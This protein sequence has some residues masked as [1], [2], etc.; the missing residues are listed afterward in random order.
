MTL[1]KKRVIF[2]EH[3]HVSAGGPIW[4]QFERRGY[5]ITRF[6]IVDEEHAKS[7]NVTP[8]WPDLLSFD[9]VVVMGAP[10]AAYD[11]AAIGNWLLPQVEKM[12]Q[13][14]NAGIPIMGICFGGQLMSR[15]LG[16]TVSRSPHAEL[17]WFEIDS[18]DELLVPRGPW[19]QYHWD[20]FT[21]PPGS[22]HIAHNELCPQAYVYGR[23]LGV[24]FHPEIDA[25]VL[26]I[27]L[28]MEGGRA[29]AESEGIIVEDLR[30][31]TK[32]L[33]RESNQRG[34]D[35]VDQFL[36]RVATA[37]IMLT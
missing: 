14:H 17:G 1:A 18:I 7:P 28:A 15:V 13:V 26:D 2:V 24:Q 5:E 27:W 10:Y 9:V 35:L 12:R 11:D 25:A 29:E 33:E 23:T 20:R 19:F 16:G 34:Y 31:Q 21:F 32:K 36:D 30:A 22:T 6:I 37:P 8:I 3:D 4:A